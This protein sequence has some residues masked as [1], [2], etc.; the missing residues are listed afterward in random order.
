MFASNA[1]EGILQTGEQLDRRVYWVDRGEP[2][3]GPV[4]LHPEEEVEG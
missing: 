4:E 2:P 3:R 1:N